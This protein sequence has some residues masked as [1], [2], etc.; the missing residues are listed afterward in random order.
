MIAADPLCRPR[1]LMGSPTESTAPALSRRIYQP[2]G[3]LCRGGRVSFLKGLVGDFMG[4]CGPTEIGE[5]ASYDA[6]F[7]N[8]SQHADSGLAPL[9]FPAYAVAVG[10]AESYVLVV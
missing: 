4:L 5:L 2:L 1:T 7:G 3:V 9:Q 8:R 10:L 6:G